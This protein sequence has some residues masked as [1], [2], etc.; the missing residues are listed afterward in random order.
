M[1]DKKNG[2]GKLI[3]SIIH[4]EEGFWLDDTLLFERYKKFPNGDIFFKDIYSKSSGYYSWA[5]GRS[6]KGNLYKYTPYG[7]G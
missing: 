6:Y 3:Y 2:W 5:D 4:V 1:N 7:T